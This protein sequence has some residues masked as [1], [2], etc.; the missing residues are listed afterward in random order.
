MNA[1]AWRLELQMSRLWKVA[2]WSLVY[3]A[4]MIRGLGLTEA[5]QPFHLPTACTITQPDLIPS[6][7][8]ITRSIT[9]KRHQGLIQLQVK[10]LINCSYASPVCYTNAM[11]A[12]LP[13][14]VHWCTRG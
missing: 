1:L 6:Q 4:M 11:Q 14:R 7:V 9:R 12:A 8:S 5:S 13:V 2:G 3:G 10:V